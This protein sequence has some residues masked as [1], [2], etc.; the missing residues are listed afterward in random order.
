MAL[1]L[2][3]A[4]FTHPRETL[5]I[6]MFIWGTVEWHMESPSLVSPDSYRVLVLLL[7]IFFGQHCCFFF[8]HYPHLKP[9]SKEMKG[10]VEVYTTVKW[11]VMVLGNSLQETQIMFLHTQVYFLCP[12]WEKCSIMEKSINFGV[13]KTWV[14]NL[15]STSYQ[16]M[17]M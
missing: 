3:T 12:I 10:P 4:L 16:E 7:Q 15:N 14:K 17:C 6:I 1:L 9:K 8:I 13:R 2:S 5:S 11:Q